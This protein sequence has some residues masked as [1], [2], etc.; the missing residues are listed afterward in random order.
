MIALRLWWR[1]L[2]RQEAQ[3]LTIALTLTAFTVTTGVL[4]TV[5]GGLHAFLG[6]GDTGI[7]SF[8]VVL[9]ETATVILMV[10]I[11]TLGGAAARLS[12]A[13]RDERL[14]ALRLA[15]MTGGQ[16]GAMAV[17]D[18]AA[19]A[20]AGA[21]LGV[22]LYLVA[23]PGIA[24]LH[25]QGRPFAWAELWVGWPLLLGAVAGVVALAVV[26][27]ALSLAKVV[28]SPLGVARRTT[29]SRLSWLRVVVAVV[30]L[31]AWAPLFRT[32]TTV[33]AMTGIL[34][35]L[36]IC[37]A[38]LNLLGPFV[39]GVVGRIAAGRARTVPML[40]AARRLVDD[41]RSAW[42]TVAGVTLATFVAGV[43][44]IAPA[45]HDATGSRG[46]AE[47][48]MLGTDLMTGA[49]L[50]LVIA[51]VLAAVSSGVSQASRLLDQRD[52][53]ALLHLA[54]TDLA[55][56]RAARLRETWLPL[57]ASVAIAA[58]TSLIIIAPIG[59]PLAWSD[60]GGVAVFLGGIVAS[61]LL[62]TAAVGVSQPLV[63]TVATA[64]TRARDEALVSRTS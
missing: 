38:I 42:R 58:A 34:V 2:R 30:V 35:V 4:L 39:L 36:G 13:R 40:L 29:P 23:L 8:Y 49:I 64:R 45:L 37:F 5:L 56:L 14:A 43:L 47:G 20:L 62:V 21:V 57:T 46:D 48:A 51:A 59:I 27:A 26:S 1:L 44:S 54:G 18:A 3:R 10:P 19:Q 41:P 28:I 24:L 60:P 55:V 15:G 16:V 9:A 53:Y 33:A 52:Q 7:G 11:L 12:I 50:T 25:F 6:R 17:V 31:A 61:V 63:A 22:G 32:V